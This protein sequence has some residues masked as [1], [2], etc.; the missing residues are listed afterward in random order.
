MQKRGWPQRKELFA[1]EE[2]PRRRIG[3]LL[4]GVYLLLMSG[5]AS[6]SVFFGVG[7]GWNPALALLF[8]FGIGAAIAYAF[9]AQKEGWGWRL[10]A[11]LNGA[12]VV[13]LLTILLAIEGWMHPALV[14]AFYSFLGAAALLYAHYRRKEAAT[15]PQ[16]QA[17]NHWEPLGARDLQPDEETVTP[18][19]RETRAA[20][21]R[22]QRT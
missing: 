6:L 21:R 12:A 9:Y 20:R 15:R 5:A 22:I 3:W 1:M 18:A 7:L 8:V 2:R 4:I 16:L 13:V 10:V 11:L 17:R 14:G 19:E